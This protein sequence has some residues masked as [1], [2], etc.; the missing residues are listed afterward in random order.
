MNFQEIILKLNEYWIKQG[1][2]IVQSY[3]LEKGAGT[4][5][6]HTFFGCLGDKPSS[7]AY[8]EPSRRPTDGRYGKNPNRLGKFYQYQVVIKPAPKDI[9]QLYLGSLKA[10]GINPKKHDIR[11]IED[12]WKSPTL[13]AC[14]VGWEVWLDGLEIS[15]F[16]YFQQMAGYQLFPI[17]I[18]I[19]YGL[20]RIAMYRQN[21]KSIF[22]IKWNNKIT[23]G[24]VH[25]EEERQFSHYCFE[26]AN[27]KNLK[28]Y[29]ND[30][31]TEAV[32]LCE[33]GLYLPAYDATMKVSHLFNLL[34]ARGAISVSDRTKLI[35]RIRNLAKLCAKQY[36]KGK[37]AK[38]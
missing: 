27:I 17:T 1:T 8:V 26:E 5:N 23:Y 35:A 14:G 16:T 9:Q 10:I 2:C 28:K 20:E 32:D 36:L 22:D 19:T 21:K 3:D 38:K 4:F 15:Q 30:Y 13:G 24:D 6:P 29:I 31:E 12:D 11:F 37:K 7:F 25:K 33:K 34:D 18:E